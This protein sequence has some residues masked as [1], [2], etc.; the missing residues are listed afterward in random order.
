MTV[1]RTERSPNALMRMLC[2]AL[3][4]VSAALILEV[5]QYAGVWSIRFHAFH[6]LLMTASWAA[7]W[8]ALRGLEAV[9]PWFLATVMRE[10]RFAVN[11]GFVVIW[12]LLLTTAYSGS[13]FASIPI[14]H[15]L[16]VRLARKFPAWR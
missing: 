11:L 14:V 12:V 8:G 13:R 3:G 7:I 1:S 10:L 9:F 15:E 6:S 16:A 2:Y 4:P 5:P